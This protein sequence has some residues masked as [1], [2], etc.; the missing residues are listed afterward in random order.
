VQITRVSQ[1]FTLRGPVGAVELLEELA[2]LA[3]EKT[4]RADC[5]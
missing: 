3:A 5:G 2:A 4:P 1:L